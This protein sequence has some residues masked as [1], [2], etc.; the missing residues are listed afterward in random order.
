MAF[1][2]INT[3]SIH[4]HNDVLAGADV[5]HPAPKMQHPSTA[6]VVYSLDRRGTAFAA[7]TRLQP[8]R[9]ECILDLREMVTT[10]LTTFK[11]KHR[12]YPVHLFFYRDGISDAEIDSVAKRVE[13]K[14]IQGAFLFDGL[15]RGTGIVTLMMLLHDYFKAALQGLGQE[16]P[17]KLTY[18]VVTKR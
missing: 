1:R 17:I 8:P 5:S 2:R 12:C 6:S 4:S 15:S 13:I 10:A 16:K 11:E 14:D 3:W 7:L 9:V 18:M